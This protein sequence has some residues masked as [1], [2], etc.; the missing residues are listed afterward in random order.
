MLVALAFN[1]CLLSPPFQDF[2][3]KVNI[4]LKILDFPKAEFPNFGAFVS[5]LVAICS[6]EITKDIFFKFFLIF[7]QSMHT[8]RA[9]SHVSPGYPPISQVKTIVYGNLDV[10]ISL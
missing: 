4:F 1:M 7:Y 10:Q 6:T 8:P 5:V 3:K 9:H 2:L